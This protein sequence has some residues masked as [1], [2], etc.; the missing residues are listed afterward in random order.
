MLLYIGS[1]MLLETRKPK[2]GTAPVP[3][4]S[5][6][7]V[8]CSEFNTRRLVFEFQGC[9]YECATRSIFL[10]SLVVGVV[11]GIYGI[12]GG[13]ILAPF[14]VG[15]VGLPVHTIAGATLMGT[16]ITSV[17]GVGFS[18]LIAPLYRDRGLEVAPDW[19]LGSLFGAGGLVGTYL[20]ARAQ[21]FVPARR[22]KGMLSVILLAVALIYL[23]G[24]LSS[25]G[26]PR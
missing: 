15:I 9:R 16:F 8:R 5:D 11:G 2:S 23:W 25:L 19:L 3:N 21:R 6:W 24:Y 14:F 10:L 20:G 18:E 26:Q 4:S 17:C 7:T 13:A 12:G 1:R 22:L